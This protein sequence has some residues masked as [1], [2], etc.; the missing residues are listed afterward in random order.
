V[1][2]RDSYGSM[3]LVSQGY[4]DMPI[5]YRSIYGRTGTDGRRP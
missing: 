3:S 1:K 2:N 4:F 5:S